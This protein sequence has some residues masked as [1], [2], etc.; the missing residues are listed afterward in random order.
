M[1][2]HHQ[3]QPEYFPQGAAQQP[4]QQ[5]PQHPQP[6]VGLVDLWR[7]SGEELEWAW[8]LKVAVEAD[9][10]LKPLSD[11]EYAHQSLYAR[12]NTEVALARVLGLQHFRKEYRIDDDAAQG[13][14]LIEAWMALHPSFLLSVDIDEIRGHFVM[15]YDYSKRKPANLKTDEDWRSHLGGMYYL[16]HAM[17]NNIHACREGIIHICE[18]EGMGWENFSYD[19][20]RRNFSDLYENYPLR[21]KEI[22]WLRTPLVGNILFA[23]I[24]P[25]MNP[26][27]VKKFR[28]GCIF[29]GYEERLDALFSIPTPEVARKNLVAKLLGYLMVRYQMEEHFKLPDLPLDPGLLDDDEYED[30]D[31]DDIIDGDDELQGSGNEMDPE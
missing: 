1:E 22:S 9:D 5:Q 7:M 30:D 20:V 17:Q 2:D 19:V 26:E 24:K 10:N 4:Q 15:I 8:E 6:Q 12:G 29:N 21:H 11:F 3:Q 13:I 23:F 14:Q 25:L 16:S 18:C 27:A 31:D 28:V